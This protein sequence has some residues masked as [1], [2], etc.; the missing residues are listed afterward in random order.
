MKKH[1]SPASLPVFSALV[2]SLIISNSV[3]AD[4]SEIIVISATA[5]QQSWLLSPASVELASLPDAGIIIDSAKLLERISGVQAD[6]RANFAQDTRLSI[7]GFGSRSAFGIRSLYLQQDGIPLSTPD[8]QGQLSSILLDNIERIEVLKGPLAALYGNAAGGV[9]SLYSRQSL[10][11]AAGVAVAGSE[12]HRQYRLYAD[13]VEGDTS[14]S[15]GIKHFET[16]GY[17]AHSAAEKQQAQ[18][19]YRTSVAQS[20]RLMAR[21]DYARDPQL[22]DPLGLSLDTWRAEPNQTDSAAMR[23][24]T[25]KNSRQ[26]QLSFSLTDYHEA[27]EWQLS[28][29]FGDRHIGQRL[30]FSGSALSSAGGEVALQRQFGGINGNYRL[31]H[32]DTFELRLGASVVQSQD[33]RQGYVNNFGQRGELRRQ[34]TDSADSKDLFAR[35]SWQPAPDWQLQGGWR[36]SQLTLAIEDQYTNSDNP[37]DSGTKRFYNQAIALGLNYRISNGI[38]AFVSMAEGFESPTL[39]EI[40]YRRDGSGVNLAL[41][42]STNRQWESGVKWQQ[43]NAKGASSSGSLS[44]FNAVTDNELLVDSAIGGRT[45]YRNAA[46]TQ[47]HGLELQLRWRPNDYWQHQLSGHYVSATFSADELKGKSLPGVAKHQWHWQLAY[48]P[49]QDRTQLS[50]HSQYRSK[51]YINDANEE[52]AP[53]AVT[54]SLSAQHSQQ[55]SQLRLDYWLALDNITDK[56]YVGSVIVNQSNGRAIE[57]APGRQLSAGITAHYVW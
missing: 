11:S 45:S 16:T 8:G 26:R 21:L 15:A 46:K 47:R 23:F 17:R 52:Q 39:A 4:D 1:L 14:L 9:I 53:G 37:D 54:F 25:E 49:W 5:Q 31:L 35:F 56:A 50:L 22:Q 30:A 44:W 29:W 24:D 2:L 41:D 38:S 40:A 43:H 36:Y 34:Q 6:S 7:R 3:H 51:V 19:L 20:V 13:W 57:P 55:L 33:D 42:A 28:S 48:R 10:H 27:D 12:Q 18:L 32:S